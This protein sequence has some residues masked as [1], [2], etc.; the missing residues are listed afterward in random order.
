MR[1]LES[2]GWDVE[3][4]ISK[5][6][7]AREKKIKFE[8]QKSQFRKKESRASVKIP[9]ISIRRGDNFFKAS[10]FASLE[11]ALIA[12]DYGDLEE[13]AEYCSGPKTYE[14][15]VSLAPDGWIVVSLWDEG[16]A[17]GGE[18]LYAVDN[19]QVIPCFVAVE[20]GLS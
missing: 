14:E 1:K 11:K 15:V 3:A 2:I 9:T 16:K 8:G 4:A 18:S 5:F 10:S 12:S 19:G 6:E 13:W 7:A 20:A 17:G